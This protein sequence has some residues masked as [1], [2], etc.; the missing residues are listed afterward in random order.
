MLADTICNLLVYNKCFSSRILQENKSSFNVEDAGTSV[1]HN[2]SQAQ[3]KSVVKETRIGLLFNNLNIYFTKSM[4]EA[5]FRLDIIY[6]FA[7]ANT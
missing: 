3:S 1:L 4:E 7:H 6:S 5:V 2:L